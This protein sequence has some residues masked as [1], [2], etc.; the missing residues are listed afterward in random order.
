MTMDI[1]PLLIFIAVGL[2]GMWAHWFKKARRNELGGRFIDYLVADYP[3]NTL[4]TLLVFIGSSVTAASAGMISGLDVGLAIDLVKQGS[5]HM[6][7]IS[8]LAGGFM[9]GWTLD[10][11]INKGA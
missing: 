6:P 1:I 9:L 4:A 11:G 10:S 2:L 8:A 7:T 3:G 5:L